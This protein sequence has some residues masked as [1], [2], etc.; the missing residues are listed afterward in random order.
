MTEVRS[1]AM[2]LRDKSTASN[3]RE[4]LRTDTRRDHERLDSLI[5]SLDISKR[6]DFAR[7]C[8]IHDMCFCA[9]TAQCSDDELS[10]LVIALE[11]DLQTLTGSHAVH[12][13]IE[14]RTVDP[15]AV[16]Y[17]VGGSRMGTKVLRTRWGKSSDPLVISANSYFSLHYDRT[18]WRKVCNELS[19]IPVGSTRAKIIVA[20]TLQIFDLFVRAFHMSANRF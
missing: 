14:L 2:V 8:N 15:L 10:E 13:R 7:F 6:Q 19:E 16:S 20:D 1:V 5:S 9:L 18:R 4:V 3:F 12:P 11:R 17:I